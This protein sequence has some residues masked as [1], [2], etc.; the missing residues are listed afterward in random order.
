VQTYRLAVLAALASIMLDGNAARAENFSV[1]YSFTG[2]PD[3]Q[4]PYAA[5]TSV[6]G[7]LYGTTFEGG[8]NNYGSVF[9]ITP[10]GVETVIYSFKGGA[11]GENPEASLINVGGVLY[12]TT[13]GG[14]SEHCGTVFKVT[15]AGAETVLY[16]FCSNQNQNDGGG[17][18]GGLIN[19][20]GA[21]YGT[22]YAGGTVDRGTV[23]KVTRAGKETVL[24]SFGA[25]D[26]GQYPEAGLINVDGTLYGTTFEGG[27]NDLGTV[28]A[29]SPAGV[30]SVLYAF[31]TGADAQYPVA[32]LVNVGSTLYGTSEFGGGNLCEKGATS[33]GAVFA[34][35]PSGHET[36]LYSFQGKPDG[37]FPVAGLINIKGNLYG[38]TP[39]GG[40]GRNCGVE[41]CGTIFK[42]TPAGVET[43]LHSFSTD[44]GIRPDAS[45]LKLGHL[46]YGT[47]SEFGGSGNGTVF[48]VEH[49]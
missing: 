23:F 18:V 15:L 7:T 32:P 43:I 2:T 4:L 29:I 48:T 46:L 24:H 28:F 17:P 41:G 16:A 30:E 19:V 11:D 49:N 8:A 21:L 45:L 22:T 33:C 5:L 14:G 38:T 13:A 35:T 20:G 47:A 10:S 25:N 39:G 27:V 3:G 42:L 34:V 37:M 9:A 6:G 26:D 44:E 36:V 12:G 40:T 31:K 1:L